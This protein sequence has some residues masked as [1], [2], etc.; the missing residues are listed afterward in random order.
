MTYCPA[1]TLLRLAR[2]QG[3]QTVN[4]LGMLPI[5]EKAFELMIAKDAI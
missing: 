5:T 2:E 4:G 1:E 3:L